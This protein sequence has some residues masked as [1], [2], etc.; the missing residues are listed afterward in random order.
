M[1]SKALKVVRREREREREREKGRQIERETR[2]I[3][4]LDIIKGTS[5]NSRARDTRC[6]RR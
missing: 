2:V 1:Q 3:L 6:D 4:A 5:F